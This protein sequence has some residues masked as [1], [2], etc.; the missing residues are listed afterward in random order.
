MP[1][2]AKMNDTDLQV[3]SLMLNIIPLLVFFFPFP[4]LFVFSR[5]HRTYRSGGLLRFLQ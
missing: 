5:P 1:P 3:P 4:L 2:V